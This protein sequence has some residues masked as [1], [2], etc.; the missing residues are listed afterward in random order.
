MTQRVAD[1]NPVA[2]PMLSV[3]AAAAEFGVS[4][5]TIRRRISEGHL[6]A[7][8]MRGSSMIRIRR[9]DLDKLFAPIPTARP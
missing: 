9:S 5:K 4:V 3:P 1:Q 2:D 7:L 6:S 8:R